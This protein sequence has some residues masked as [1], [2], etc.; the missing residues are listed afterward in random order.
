MDPIGYHYPRTL[1]TIKP[2]IV[3]HHNWNERAIPRC[4]LYLFTGQV[5]V[6]VGYVIL[7]N[8]ISLL[9]RH[10]VGECLCRSYWSGQLV[11]HLVIIETVVI[12]EIYIEK[13]R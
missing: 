9:G 7:T 11:A 3:E 12:F 13:V 2:L 1:F 4:N 5:V 6:H 8:E 10:V